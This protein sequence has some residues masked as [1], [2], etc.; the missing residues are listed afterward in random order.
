MFIPFKKFKK[1]KHIEISD[2]KLIKFLED[3]NMLPI[4]KKDSVY[5]FVDSKELK[6]MIE[7]YKS[8]G[9]QV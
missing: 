8:E 2:E 3:N 7:K 9:L 1:E 5:F 6:I 4:S